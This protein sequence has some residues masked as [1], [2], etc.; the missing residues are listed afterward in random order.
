MM[1]VGWYLYD[2]AI[3][4]FLPLFFMHA[5]QSG[6]DCGADGAVDDDGGGHRG[7]VREWLQAFFVKGYVPVVEKYLNAAAAVSLDG[8]EREIKVYE[9]MILPFLRLRKV[10]YLLFYVQVMTRDD[11]AASGDALSGIA[12]LGK[13]ICSWY[14]KK[15]WLAFSTSSRDPL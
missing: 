9:E 14:A 3:A 13:R 11:L 12:R 1:Q 4:L 15:G 2:V 10:Y 6:N 7:V 5:L 8:D